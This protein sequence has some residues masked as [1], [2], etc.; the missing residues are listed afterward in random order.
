MTTITQSVGRRSVWLGRMRFAAATAAFLVPLHLAIAAVL[1]RG[2]ERPIVLSP[3]PYGPA[4]GLLLVVA[5]WAGAGIA[6]LI[7]QERSHRRLLLAIGLALVLVAAERGRT[8]GTMDDWLIL[9]NERPGPPV[10]GPYWRLLPDYAYLIAGVAGA[11][12]IA[13]LVREGRQPGTPLRGKL[14][15]ALIGV[16]RGAWREGVVALLV[17]AVLGGVAICILMG[18]AMARTYRGQVCFAVLVG[19]LAGSL[20]GRKLASL[21]VVGGS[22]GGSSRGGP[23]PNDAGAADQ[24]VLLWCAGAPFVLG[25]VG[26]VAAAIRPGLALPPGCQ[27]NIIPAWA[28]SRALPVEMVGLGLVGTLWFYRGRNGDAA[29]GGAE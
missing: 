26:L 21:G 29:G 2:V 5:I 17:T 8:G 23:P 12:V 20:A 6:T 9:C 16:G 11:M 3:S 10:G 13:G 4:A 7:D 18:P 25:V 24:T 28:L 19:S 15:R 14:M 1:P 22:G 27:L